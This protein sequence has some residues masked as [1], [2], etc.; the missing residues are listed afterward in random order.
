MVAKIPEVQLERAIG[1]KVNELAH[2]IEV[3]SLA[4]RSEPI[5]LYSSP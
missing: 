3:G 5:T 1:Q 2:V 4:V